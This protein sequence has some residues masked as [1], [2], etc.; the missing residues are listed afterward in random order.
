MKYLLIIGLLLTS[1]GASADVF[2]MY[3]TKRGFWGWLF[4]SRY[5]HCAVAD[6][7]Q[8]VEYIKLKG[9]AR[10]GQRGEA[11]YSMNTVA[12]IYLEIEYSN[13]YESF[14]SMTC[15]GRHKLSHRL[16]KI[17]KRLNNRKVIVDLEREVRTSYRNMVSTLQSKYWDEYEII[18]NN[19]ALIDDATN[20]QI[21]SV[22]M[23]LT[24]QRCEIR[25]YTAHDSDIEYLRST[26]NHYSSK[27]IRNYETHNVL[28]GCVVRPH[29]VQKIIYQLAE[30]VF[31][32]PSKNSGEDLPLVP[33]G[34][35][36]L[37]DHL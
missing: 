35:P 23:T 13:K 34:P 8:E 36:A 18:S 20:G 21:I 10:R 11:V 3:D 29:D 26:T 30:K 24:D 15:G 14:G 32:G 2:D 31:H 4:N 12:N 33:K 17:Q 1:F 28:E 9:L 16:T 19:A 25:A 22:L 27:N 6:E 5:Q 37:R 7:M